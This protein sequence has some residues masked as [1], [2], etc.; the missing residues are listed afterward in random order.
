MCVKKCICLKTLN[1]KSLIKLKLFFD[2]QN[3]IFQCQINSW[4]LIHKNSVNLEGFRGGSDE[5]MR[6]MWLGREIVVALTR[7]VS[8]SQLVT[9]SSDVATLS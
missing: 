5:K 7:S 3:Y 1:L 6:R 4:S 8:Y 9:H 2:L